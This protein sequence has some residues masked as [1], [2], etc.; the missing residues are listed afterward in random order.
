MKILILSVLFCIFLNSNA[1]SNTSLDN[2]IREYAVVMS[3]NFTHGSELF[4]AIV[5]KSLVEQGFNEE[6]YILD[7]IKKIDKDK[8]TREATYYMWYKIFKSDIRLSTQLSSMGMSPYNAKII[9]KHIS[10]FSTMPLS[11]GLSS[12]SSSEYNISRFSN[13]ELPVNN[14]EKVGR[15]A[16][17]FSVDKTGKVTSATP[18]TKGTT[19]GDK[20]LYQKCKDAL[21]NARFIQQDSIINSGIIIFKFTVK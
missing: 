21:M 2:A 3:K 1:Q 12:N 6:Q 17:R 7:G 19:L 20:E 4:K 11:Q 16:V 18:G 15:I 5:T 8:I 9:S 13:L 14:G 10:E